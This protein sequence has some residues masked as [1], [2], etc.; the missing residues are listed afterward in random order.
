MKK[1]IITSILLANILLA[2]DYVGVL[3]PIEEFDIKSETSGKIVN[4]KGKELSNNMLISINKSLEEDKLISLKNK[5][6]ILNENLRIKEKQYNTYKNI[7]TKSE[8][9]KDN[10]YLE[11][12]SLKATIEDLKLSIKELEDVISKKEIKINGYYIKDLKISKNEYVSIGS[13]LASIENQTQSKVEFFIDKE[14]LNINLNNLITKI[15][16]KEVFFDEIEISNNTDETYISQYK[17]ILKSNK[18][19]NF[20]S[21]VEIGI[22]NENK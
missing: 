22:K 12:L 4:I 21:I 19:F 15:D 10:K 5:L 2:N 18:I 20:G 9:E 14:Y 11:V 17:V 7:Q 6:N 16:N 1:I 8:F 13:V 3:K